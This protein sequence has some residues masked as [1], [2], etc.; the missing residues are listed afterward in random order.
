MSVSHVTVLAAS[1]GTTHPPTHSRTHEHAVRTRAR[2]ANQPT[3][4]A[5]FLACHLVFT[6][7]TLGLD[8]I[9][10]LA[11]LRLH[12][13]LL[14]A[15]QDLVEE[16]PTQ[17]PSLYADT[18]T[19]TRTRTRTRIGARTD[20][21]RTADSCGVA[22]PPRRV[23]GQLENNAVAR[24]RNCCSLADVH[25]TSSRVLV[26]TTSEHAAAHLQLVLYQK[27][28]VKH[29]WELSRHLLEL[30]EVDYTCEPHVDGKWW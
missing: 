26:L 15:L 17:R 4:L 12:A 5:P 6:L 28:R 24:P 20:I 14:V 7:L 8:E 2:P 1:H 10:A 19:T 29:G 18:Q 9:G 22:A 21:A 30:L 27:R 11:L 16:W 23:G 3:H 25:G 13:V